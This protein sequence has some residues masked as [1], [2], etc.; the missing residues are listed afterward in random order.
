MF[1][2]FSHLKR[3]LIPALFVGAALTIASVALVS[4]DG[5]VTYYACNAKGTL[6]SVGT[7]QPTCKQGGTLM[8]WNQVGPMGP[9][10]PQGEKGD[11]GAQGD[12][13][14]Q[15]LQGP[16]GDTG[17]QG[18]QGVQGDP[19]P[20]GPKGDKGDTGDTGATGPQG[21]Q[22]PAGLSGWTMRSVPATVQPGSPYRVTYTCAP[23]EK[24]LTGGYSVD[25]YR[26][27]GVDS[28]PIES[29]PGIWGWVVDFRNEDGQNAHSATVYTVCA[30]TD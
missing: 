17:P 20:T 13:G 28:H 12:I 26:L 5:P 22:G 3:I 29:P 15:G 8:T 24:I 25:D 21:P 7:T 14:P 23:G 16:Q 11:A 30:L 18:L 27:K 4:A 6:Y 10:G 19:G 1:H 9:V 2:K